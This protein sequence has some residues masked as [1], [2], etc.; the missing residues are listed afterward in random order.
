MAGVDRISGQ[1]LEQQ[2]DDLMADLFGGLADG[3]QLGV[4]VAGEADVV[5]AHH[6]DV[7]R[8]AQAPVA[9]G[10]H[11]AHGHLVAEAEDSGRRRGLRQQGLALSGPGFDGEIA[12][13][14]RE[15]VGAAP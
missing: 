1:D 6:R 14:D 12:G 8:T 4:E 2:A 15:G 9:D 7:P 11:G 5:E 10:G 3:G 13:R